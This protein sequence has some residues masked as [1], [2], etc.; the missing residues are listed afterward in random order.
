MPLVPGQK[1]RIPAVVSDVPYSSAWQNSKKVPTQGQIYDVLIP[2][3]PLSLFDRYA[4]ATTTG[5]TVEPLYTNIVPAGMLANAG[6]KILFKY[7]GKYAANINSKRIF[8]KFAGINI[9]DSKT[10]P[11]DA[12]KWQID[13]SIIRVDADSVRYESEWAAD[14]AP[15]IQEGQ[16]DLLDLALDDFDLQLL[17]TTPIA[18]GDATVTVGYAYFVPAAIVEPAYLAFLNET[19]VFDGSALKFVP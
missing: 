11:A 4:D 16:I 10:Q 13:G 12:V 6:D 18:A 9:A 3:L 15:I 17:A 5:L 7:A 1:E 2:R 14:I 19:L 8:V